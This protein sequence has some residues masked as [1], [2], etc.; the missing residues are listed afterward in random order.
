MKRKQPLTNTWP[1]SLGYSERGMKALLFERPIWFATG[2]LSIEEE[3]EME[4]PIYHRPVLVGE[5]LELLAPKAGSLV[6]D[7]TCGGGGHSE[8]ILRAGANIL[9]LDQDPDAIEYAAARL[10]TFAERIK[11]RQ[12]NFR[13]INEVLDQLGI[14]RIGG[15]LLD[16]GVSSRQLE[17]AERGFSIMRPGPLDMR[18]DPRSEL[19]AATI[20][21]SYGEEELTQLV[22]RLRRRAGRATHRL[23][24]RENA[25]NSAVS[26][27]R[28]A[29]ARDR[30][31]C[32]PPRTSSSG[33][34]GF[35]SV[36]HGSKR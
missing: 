13:S 35:P 36:A 9:A 4:D 24:D 2:P 6:V 31:D 12:C 26:R 5:V 25:K 22:S 33:Y 21:N 7:A 32:R 19:T 34:A 17:S 23:D 18:M 28:F 10:S 3:A 29:C 15:A 20:L 16:L 14:A 30:E 27:Y 11:F 8:A 1:I